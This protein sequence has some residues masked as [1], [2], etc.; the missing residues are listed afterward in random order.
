MVE[1][2]ALAIWWVAINECN[3]FIL[4]CLMAK[5]VR[6]FH[7]KGPCSQQCMCW[8]CGCST[9]P[10]PTS[11]SECSWSSSALTAEHDWKSNSST[12]IPFCPSSCSAWWETWLESLLELINLSVVSLWQTSFSLNRVSLLVRKITVQRHSS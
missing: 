11:G 3:K 9:D 12:S 2:L 10:S 4:F 6:P 8:C 5:N 7:D 1:Y